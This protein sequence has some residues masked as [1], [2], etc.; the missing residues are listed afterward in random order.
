MRMS[1]QCP[2]DFGRRLHAAIAIAKISKTELAKRVG[3]SRVYL[4]LICSG[5]R[6]PSKPVAILIEQ[7]IGTAGWNYTMGWTDTLP[8][9]AA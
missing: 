6:K 2:P 3:V 5:A 9:G 4:T 8:T 7:Q 1:I